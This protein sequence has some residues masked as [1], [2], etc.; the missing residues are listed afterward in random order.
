MET[1]LLNR[2]TIEKNNFYLNKVYSFLELL[3]DEYPN[4][5]EWYF[6]NIFINNK[7]LQDRS[8][9]LK[10]YKNE[11]C[12]VSIIKHSEDKICTFRVT[13]KFHG[14]SIGTKLMEDSIRIIGNNRPLIT[15]SEDR[16]NQFTPILKKFDFKLYATYSNYYKLNKTEFSFNKPIEGVEQEIYIPQLTY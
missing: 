2:L 1:I 16:L 14:L 13:E 11:I 5:K 9:I 8:L 10:V 7:L 3:E 12:A 4:F 6:N 15:V